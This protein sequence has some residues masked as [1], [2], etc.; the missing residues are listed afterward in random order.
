MANM[1]DKAF[2]MNSKCDAIELTCHLPFDNNNNNINGYSTDI[3]MLN[4][5]TL[6][7]PGMRHDTA[8][9]IVDKNSGKK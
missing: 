5:T 7:L 4:K 9:V 6:T 3:E 2:F 1:L 8:T